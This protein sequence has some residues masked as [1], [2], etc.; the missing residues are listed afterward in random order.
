MSSSNPVPPPPPPMPPPVVER[1]DRDRARGVQPLWVLVFSVAALCGVLAVASV[2]AAL[3][4]LSRPSA[5][6]AVAD[7]TAVEPQS[8]EATAVPPAIEHQARAPSVAKPPPAVSFEF[9]AS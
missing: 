1:S 5:R 2:T 8:A 9:P 6:Q 7:V 3:I 4:L